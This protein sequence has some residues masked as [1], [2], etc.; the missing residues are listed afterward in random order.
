MRSAVLFSLPLV[1]SNGL[2][3]R[4]RSV[5]GTDSVRSFKYYFE[6]VEDACAHGYYIQL[7]PS[8]SDGAAVTLRDESPFSTG[9]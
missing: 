2:C 9:P 7:E 1:T 5:D 4:W 8:C 3:W 6:C